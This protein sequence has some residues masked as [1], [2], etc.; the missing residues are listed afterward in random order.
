MTDTTPQ[1]R[2]AEFPRDNRQSTGNETNPLDD[3]AAFE[4]SLEEELFNETLSEGIDD[5]AHDVGRVYE[6]RASA[7]IKT[8]TYEDGSKEITE[9][10]DLTA[11]WHDQGYWRCHTC[12]LKIKNKSVAFL[13]ASDEATE[14]VEHLPPAIRA[15][16]SELS[17]LSEFAPDNSE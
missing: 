3:P 8:F 16:I 9:S 17:S 2:S 5:K 12:G 7:S 15:N 10:D 1:E 13:H 6:A 11:T 4:D 14:L